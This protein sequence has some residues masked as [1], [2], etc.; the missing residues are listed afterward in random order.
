MSAA[1]RAFRALI[2]GAPASG[3]GTISSRIVKK[4]EFHHISSG[5]LLR[6]NIEKATGAGLKAVE[7]VKSGQLV[8]DDVVI[9]CMLDK[10]DHE[11]HNRILLDGFPRVGGR[12]VKQ[13]MMKI[14]MTQLSHFSIDPLPSNCSGK[15]DEAGR[16]S[17]PH[18]ALRDH[19]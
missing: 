4:Y 11:P 18:C 2:M 10:I 9:D 19:H 13:M 17:A 12:V 6:W 15:G 3:K 5:D 14:V 1:T 7:Y 8:P 16:D